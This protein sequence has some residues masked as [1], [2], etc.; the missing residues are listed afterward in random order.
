MLTIAPAPP[1]DWTAALERAFAQTPEADRPARV[2]QCHALLANGVLDPRGVWAARTD[3]AIIAAQVCV[4]L[5]GAA[6]LFW[7]PASRGEAADALVRAGL[8]W[9]RGWHCKLAQALANDAEMLWTEPLLRSGFRPIT[10]L[11]Q[12]ERQLHDLPTAV[13]T[14][15]RFEAYR[16]SLA[17]EFAATLEQTY[18]GTLDCPELNGRRSVDEILAGHRGQG[19]FDPHFWWLAYAGDQPAGVVLLAEMPDGLTCELA[20]LGVVPQFRRHGVGRAMTLHAL[21]NCP[22]T[23]MTL[24]VDVRNLPAHRLYES[25]GFRE[26]ETSTVLL[27]F[28]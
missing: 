3:G 28:F 19:R 25:L 8:D 16:P 23:R 1:E 11:C 5:A 24:V 26:F 6:C 15:L 22:A 18:L 2:A 20:Y 7:L 17:A 21:C 4:P 10:R 14:D 13:D 27:F 12:L 9:C